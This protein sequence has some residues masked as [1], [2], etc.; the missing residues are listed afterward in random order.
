MTPR[1]I[2]R[3]LRKIQIGDI[4]MNTS[5]GRQL[6][7]RRVARPGLGRARILDAL[8]LKLPERLASPDRIL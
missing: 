2:L 4:L 5:D 1:A 3:E 7:L 8:K 6:A